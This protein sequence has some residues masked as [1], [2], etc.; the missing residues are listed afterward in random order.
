MELLTVNISGKVRREKLQGREY[1]VAPLTLIVPGVLNGNL[2][3][4]FYPLEDLKASYDAWNGMPIVAPNHPRDE[5]GL[6]VSARLPKIWDKHGIGH[7]FNAS[8]NDKLAAEGW[9][10]IERTKA[11]DARILNAL[12]NGQ[13]MELST[14]LN[15]DQDP[16]PGVW[17]GVNGPVPYIAVARK[18]RPDH[19]AIL[20]DT[21]G[22]C[23]VKDGC[24]LNVNSAQDAGLVQRIVDTVVERVGS[25]LKGNSTPVVVN[26]DKKM[27]KLSPEE[28]TNIITALVANACCKDDREELEKASDSVLR[29]LAAGVENEKKSS[30][31]AR[32]VDA[33][34][35]VVEAAKK[36]FQVG[37]DKYTLDDKGEWVRVED[38][39]KQKQVDNQQTP[40]KQQIKLEDLPAELQEDIAFARN[41]KQQRK[42][43]LIN[44]LVANIAQEQQED[45]RKR[46]STRSLEEL[47]QDVALLPKPTLNRNE[48]QEPSRFNFLGAGAGQA[49][50]NAGIAKPEP[51][52]QPVWNFEAAGKDS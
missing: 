15:L 52:G 31:F 34:K 28:R 45:Q 37:N 9:F 19:L 24:G 27:S 7:V 16:V 11:V 30:E 33:Q 40:A 46:L 20:P 17:N 22:A 38:P 4:L 29:A 44:K 51:L 14:G 25:L 10:D 6:P 21:Q 35:A 13:K 39:A 8:V 23:S 42:T 43:E 32:T 12:L 36:G 3:P 5:V 26:E 48:A 18:F 49:V 47:E 41:A 2:G 50:H 1:L